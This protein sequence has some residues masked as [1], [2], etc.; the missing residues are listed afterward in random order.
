MLATHAL[1]QAQD[2]LAI[3]PLEASDRAGLA[4]L[5][6]RMSA[7]SRLRRFLVPKQELTDGELD[8]L[9]NVD[10]SSH[11]A[12]VAVDADGRII[13]VAR[14]AAWNGRPH[15]AEVSAV[16]VDDW[17]RQGIGTSLMQLLVARACANGLAELTAATTWEN[18]PARG[19][20]AKC[21]FRGRGTQAGMLE[22]SRSLRS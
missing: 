7:Q 16:V 19:L 3:R 4:D 6:A 11:E 22:L 5:F 12:L 20:L 21:G 2:A 14:Y 9:S 17:Q 15:I 1:H 13:G 18:H 10:H 8:Y